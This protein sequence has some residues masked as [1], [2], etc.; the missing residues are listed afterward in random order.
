MQQLEL[1]L[2]KYWLWTGQATRWSRFRR[3]T[4]WTQARSHLNV[5]TKGTKSDTY[6]FPHTKWYT[7]I[8]QILSQ[9]L[10]ASAEQNPSESDIKLPALSE[11]VI[12]Y[13]SP[14][15][16]FLKLKC[17]FK[18][19]LPFSYV[20]TAQTGWNASSFCKV[21]HAFFNNE[22]ATTYSVII[23]K[24]NPPRVFTW[25]ANPKNSTRHFFQ[26]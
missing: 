21:K 7:K 22:T 8:C 5:S 14:V 10:K 26:N 19:I 12:S 24:Q 4:W 6:F 23:L 17:K 3:L 16:T 15:E 1:T 2:R 20:P 9:I 18:L 25:T 11:T 13:T